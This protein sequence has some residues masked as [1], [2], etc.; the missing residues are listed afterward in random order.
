MNQVTAW[1]LPKSEMNFQFLCWMQEKK[2]KKKKKTLY[3]IIFLSIFLPG[4]ATH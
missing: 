4:I 3:L 1:L 2:K